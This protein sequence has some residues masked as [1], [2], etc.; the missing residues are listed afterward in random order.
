MFRLSDRLARSLP[1][2]YGYLMVPVAVVAQI[3][4][5]P[6][7]TFAV[8]AFM[9]SIRETLALSDTRM[10]L[11]YMLGTLLAAVPLSLVGP[12]SDRVGLR[13]TTGAV[14]IGLI[15]TCW[16]ASYVQGF[17]TLLLAFSLLR[18]L[19]QGSLTLLSGNVVSMWFQQKL[20]TVTA[21]MSAGMAAAFGL[22][23]PTLLWSIETYGWRETYRLVAVVIAI[24]L[25]PLIALVFRNRP[26]DV[27]QL[28]DGET[29]PQMLGAGSGQDS[30]TGDTGDETGI[31]FENDLR[32]MAQPIQRLPIRAVSLHEAMAHRTYWI[33]AIS[34]STWAMIGTGLVFYALEIFANQGI[35]PDR[36]KV[37]FA[38]FSTAMLALQIVG[39]LLADRLPLNRLLAVAF[40]C[41]TLGALAVPLTSQPLHMHL[42]AAFFGAGQGLAISVSSTMWVRYY[43]RENL[44]KIRGAV[45]CMTVAGSGCGPLILGQ[46]SDLLDSYQI[47]L[48][49][50]V[51]ML[52]PLSV[53]TLWATPPPPNALPA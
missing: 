26:E 10:A 35:P 1:F 32:D 46:L 16:G 43:G 40:A 48:W 14:A 29:A 23:P 38:T 21:V 50:F 9:P 45:W 12:L 4:T 51:A 44:G 37:L 27:G 49:L 22:V 52:A 15:S 20:G 47:G 13:W 11:A 6:G 17:W 24:S 19:G 34:L 18:F 53:L 3:C 33:L 36:S 7:Q 39:G 2:Y 31:D 5:S 25:L 8:S 42:F 30:D 28:P 41:L